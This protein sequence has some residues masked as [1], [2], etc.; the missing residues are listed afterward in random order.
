MTSSVKFDVHNMLSSE[1]DRAQD[2]NYREFRKV[3]TIGRVVIEIGVRTDR[4]MNIQ[5]RRWQYLA[6]LPWAK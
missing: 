1:D 3:W 5:T 2:D 4:H 6:S